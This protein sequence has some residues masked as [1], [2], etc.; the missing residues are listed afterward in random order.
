MLMNIE[1]FD[2]YVARILSHLYESF[3]IKV[4]LDARSITGHEEI[5][6][7]GQPLDERGQ[8][9]K[10]FDICLAT[11]DWLVDSGYIR[12]DGR[13]QYG[14]D[15]AVL[16]ARGLEVLKATPESVKVKIS[17]GEKLVRLVKEGSIDMAKEA[18]KAAI[19]VGVGV[20][21]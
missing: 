9:S 15:L 13:G 21:K 16:T 3:P 7:M 17:I 18:A 10:R 19:A 1:L 4:H 11:I 5:D 20:M 6:E 14:Y 12:T 2:E 8:P